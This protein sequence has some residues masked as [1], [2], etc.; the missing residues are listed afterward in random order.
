MIPLLMTSIL[1]LIRLLNKLSGHIHLTIEQMIFPSSL[2][3]GKVQNKRISIKSST[4]KFTLVENVA[5]IW[6]EREI[7]FCDFESNFED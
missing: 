5:I 1:L 4:L 2:I 7:R 3:K 6:G